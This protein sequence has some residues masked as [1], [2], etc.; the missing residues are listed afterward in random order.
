LSVIGLLRAAVASL[1]PRAYGFAINRWLCGSLVLFAAAYM[2]ILSLA[3]KKLDRYVMPSV[4]SLDLVAMLGWI[5]V[6][7]WLAGRI[8]A[9]GPR[10]AQAVTAVVIGVVL[11]GQ[12]SLAVETRPYYINAATPLLGGPAGAR[13]SISFGWG[14]GG[15][16]VAE[17]LLTIP[18]IAERVVVA[19]PWPITID[20]YLP[21]QVEKPVYELTPEGAAQWLDTDY[22][23]VTA[24]EVQRQFYPP[25]LLDWFDRQEPMMTVVD[26]G[27]VYARIYDLRGMAL[28][29]PFFSAPEAGV[30]QL[31]GGPLLLA[32]DLPSVVRQGSNLRVHLYWQ[33]AG[34]ASNLL[35]ESDV[36]AADGSVV[37]RRETSHTIA[38]GDEAPGK[39]SFSVPLPDDLAPGDYTVRV[40][41]RD[42]GTGEPIAATSSA[43]GERQAYP[44]TLG[45]FA[46][47]IL[48]DPDGDTGG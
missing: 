15:K 39:L 34:G 33:G 10:M 9:I 45:T 46:V 35:I 6:T 7:L 29:E 24:P 36:L 40:T 21:F 42:A 22:L 11:I 47:E 16:S 43:T 25:A 44:I 4:I 23:V 38:A 2:V 28:P 32:S 19:G 37:G 1:A 3:A 18:G 5:A 8:V 17:A 26:D 13:D 14:E 31:E 20:F 48:P 12:A 30:T 27:Y 41:V